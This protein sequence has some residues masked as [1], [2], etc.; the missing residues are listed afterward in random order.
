MEESTGIWNSGYRPHFELW[1]KEFNV[2]R[3]NGFRVLLFCRFGE[4]LVSYSRH[5]SS[6][7]ERI[8]LESSSSRKSILCK[9]R[10]ILLVSRRI[11]LDASGCQ[12][13]FDNKHPSSCV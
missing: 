13:T 11:H 4:F 3:G 5:E 2:N 10:S 12:W 8:L 1:E 6:S 7:E 9:R